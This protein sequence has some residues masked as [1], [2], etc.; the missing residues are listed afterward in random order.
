MNC[1]VMPERSIHVWPAWS[2]PGSRC[3]CGAI[4][5]SNYDAT[6][7]S[8]FAMRQRAPTFPETLTNTASNIY[9]LTYRQDT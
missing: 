8:N 7:V 9:V 4:E 2:L 3:V 1:S 5:K 6:Y